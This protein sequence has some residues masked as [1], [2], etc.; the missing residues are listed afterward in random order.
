MLGESNVLKNREFHICFVTP[1]NVGVSNASIGV[2]SGILNNLKYNPKLTAQELA[3]KLNKA[4]RTIERNIKE[5]REKGI[6]SRI[7]SDKTGYWKI[8]N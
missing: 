1:E 7:D 8:N 4:K 3:T 5:L 2:K 6:I